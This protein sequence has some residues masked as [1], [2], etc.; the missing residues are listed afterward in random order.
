LFRIIFF[1]QT[2]FYGSALAEQILE[3]KGILSRFLYIP[4]YFCLINVAAG[5][6]LI[7]FFR[8]EKQVLW[9]PRKG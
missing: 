2:I 3:K 6:A 8:G 5:H 4:Y 7:K 9:T 1:L